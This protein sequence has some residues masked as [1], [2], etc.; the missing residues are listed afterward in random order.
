MQAGMPALSHQEQ[1]QAAERI[2]QLMEE[3]MSSGQAIAMVAQEIRETHQGGQVAVRFDD[4]DDDADQQ[5][6]EHHDEDE[7]DD[8]GY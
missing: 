8:H 6:A 7:E 4:E 5:D 3:G 1:Q 2:H